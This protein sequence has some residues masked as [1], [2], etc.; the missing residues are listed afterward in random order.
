M[1]SDFPLEYM[2]IKVRKFIS[3][4]LLLLFITPKKKAKMRLA[5]GDMTQKGSQLL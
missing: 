2:L 1:Q 4:L 3:I 5:L